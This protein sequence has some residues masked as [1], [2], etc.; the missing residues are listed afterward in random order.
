MIK[1]VMHDA[2]LEYHAE[3][4][5]SDRKCQ[6]PY[7]FTPMWDIKLN[8]TNEQTKTRRHTTACWLPE[9]KEMGS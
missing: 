6:K 5:K 3:S 4:N 2:P 1:I 7:G 8:A 9:G